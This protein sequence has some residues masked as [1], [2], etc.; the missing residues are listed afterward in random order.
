[1][2]LSSTLT[3]HLHILGNV[4]ATT[5]LDALLT[6]LTGET[7]SAVVPLYALRQVAAMKDALSD[8]SDNT[9]LG[10]GDAAAAVVTG[11]NASAT[12][13]SET[14]AIEL[15]MPD[16]YMAAGT[17]TVIVRAKVAVAAEVSNTIDLVAKENADGALG[18]DICATA[19]QTLTTSYAN[20]SF[21]ITATALV[22]GDVLNL[23]FTA[24]VN[25]T[26]GAHASIITIS[27]ITMQYSGK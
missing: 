1:M 17:V 12:T 15:T 9:T 27:K 7:R 24:A 2:A 8:T 3:N 10:L 16:N 21:T 22:A 18:A 23:A 13:K 6:I 4:T 25:D 14:A 19:V 5:E 11:S 26:G 20:Y